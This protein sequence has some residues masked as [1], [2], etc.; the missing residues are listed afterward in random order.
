LSKPTPQT[1]SQ[2]NPILK[3]ASRDT[4]AQAPL[5]PSPQLLALLDDGVS[6]LLLGHKNPDGDAVG[7]ALALG[8]LLTMRGKQVQVAFPSPPPE[9]W[10]QM[11]GAEMVVE[12]PADAP[13]VVVALD[14]DGTARLG[15]LETF[16]VQSDRCA[17]IDHHTSSD[18]SCPVTY[19]DPR[20]SATGA[21][22]Y[23]IAM[24]MGVSLNAEMATCIFWAIASDTG[25]FQFAN[26]DPEALAIC[27]ACVAAGADARA[28]A[29]LTL[30][31]RPLPH[32][33]LKGLA[34]SRLEEALDGRVLLSVIGP[35]DFASAGATRTHAE[36]IIDNMKLAPDNDVFVLFK[37]A[38]PGDPWDVSLRSE[39]VDCASVARQ[40]G[41][42]GHK[43]AAGY[44]FDSSLEDGRGRLLR[45]LANLLPKQDPEQ[46][47]E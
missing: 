8:H 2:T 5:A 31:T 28:I 47:D 18:R 40:L 45:A 24:A 13:D 10:R 26:T 36:E 19:L 39:V 20:A 22:V 11:P 42:G 32:L 16:F 33:I 46:D 14:C 43:E 34:L 25:F 21:L 27:S 41:G 15:R 44:S 7:S 6:F 4:E 23:R 29:R 30:G 38:S 3:T 9:W 37:S 35:D 12:H 1:P 17:D